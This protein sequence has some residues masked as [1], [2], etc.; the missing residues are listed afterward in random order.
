MKYLRNVPILELLCLKSRF[1]QYALD[2]LGR[3]NQKIT[4]NTHQFHSFVK[5]PLNFPLEKYSIVENENQS[6]VSLVLR[7]PLSIQH[8]LDE[9]EIIDGKPDPEGHYSAPEFYTIVAP[10]SAF[11]HTAFRRLS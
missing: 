10:F 5:C 1:S 7:D 9:D 8:L 2:T 6:L 3:K 11:T 4:V